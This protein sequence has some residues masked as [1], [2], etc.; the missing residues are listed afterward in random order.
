MNIIYVSS[1]CSKSKHVD[2]VEKKITSIMCFYHCFK[3]HKKYKEYGWFKG[4]KMMKKG[5]KSVK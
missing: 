5:I 4:Y 3:H 2:L 1:V